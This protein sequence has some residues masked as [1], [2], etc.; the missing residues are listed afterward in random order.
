MLFGIRSLKCRSWRLLVFTQRTNSKRLA[1]RKQ[2]EPPRLSQNRFFGTTKVD[3][4]EVNSW[5]KV[6]YPL[7]NQAVH[8]GHGSI[9]ATDC[10]CLFH[11]PG[12]TWLDQPA[13]SA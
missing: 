10:Q 2:K 8:H 5:N 13:G 12:P 4:K 6:S 3:K 9:A 11:H 1:T 7:M